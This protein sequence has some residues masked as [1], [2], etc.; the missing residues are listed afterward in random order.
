MPNYLESQHTCNIISYILSF[1]IITSYLSTACP[2]Y[3][4]PILNKYDFSSLFV[5]DINKVFYFCHD[6]KAI[7]KHITIQFTTY[8]LIVAMGVLLVNQ[9]CN[10]HTHRLPDGTVIMHAHPYDKSAEE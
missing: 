3:E 2:K 5:L 6:L 7:V 10:T 4:K 9:A 1:K 8:L